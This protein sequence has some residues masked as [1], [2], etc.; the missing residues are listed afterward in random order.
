MLNFANLSDLE[1]E[2]LCKDVMSATLKVRLER[3]GPGRDDGVD[4]TDDAYQKNI[5]VQVKHYIATDVRGVI[6]S[7]KKEVPK[8]QALNPEQ[9]YVCCPK[10]LT[11][12]NKQEIYALFQDYMDSTANII[13]LIELNDFLEKEENAEILRRHF[14]LWLESTNI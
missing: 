12:Q 11:P 3:F 2:Y 8:V 1:F 13:T 10:E 4:L 9:Y 6:A 14:K 7:L 5:V